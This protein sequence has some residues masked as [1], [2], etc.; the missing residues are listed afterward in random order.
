[1]NLV[2]RNSQQSHSLP[3]TEWTCV[4]EDDSCYHAFRY[5]NFHA[6]NLED[7]MKMTLSFDGE[8]PNCG[9]KHSDT[10]PAAIAVVEFHMT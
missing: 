4:Q 1:M 9:E 10:T 6:G 8:P 2:Y 7:G 5:R 3:F